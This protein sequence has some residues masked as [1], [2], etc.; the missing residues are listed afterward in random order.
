M[1]TPGLVLLA[2]GG[3]TRLGRSKQLLRWKER[4]LL[5]RAAEVA[6]ASGCQPV[7]V[8]LGA[9]AE[10]HRPELAGLPVHLVDNTRW[11]EGMGGSLCLGLDTALREEPTLG[12]VVLMVCDQ[13]AVD[14]AHLAALR[15]RHQETGQPIIASGYAGTVGVPA[16]FDRAVFAELAALPAS[17][18][19]RPVLQKDS[20]RV[21]VVP[22]PGGELDVDTPEDAERLLRT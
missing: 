11:R 4:S 19:A 3:S 17:A 22:L 9:D 8:V 2:A 20:T 14:A 1:K 7:V 15:Q 16:L 12:A 6:V 13:P 18:G 5:R 10:A 21:A